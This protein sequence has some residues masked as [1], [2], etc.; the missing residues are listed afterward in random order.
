MKKLNKKPAAVLQQLIAIAQKSEGYA[1][2][3]TNNYNPQLGGV[4]PVI[5]EERLP[6]FFLG[7]DAECWSIAHYYTLNGDLMSDPFME[8]L[9]FPEGDCYAITFE[10]HGTISTYQHAL[11]Y[12]TEGHVRGYYPNLMKDMTAFANQWLADIARM[13]DLQSLTESLKSA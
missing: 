13:Q 4:M 5:V 3:D 8:F 7:R 11:T 10:M 1:K 9:V 12:D 6:L 2:I